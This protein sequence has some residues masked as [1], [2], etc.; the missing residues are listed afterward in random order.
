MQLVGMIFKQ[1]ELVWRTLHD[2]E[3]EGL[4][5]GGTG[6][7]PSSST[8]SSA[9]AAQA[10][11]VPVCTGPVLQACSWQGGLAAWDHPQWIVEVK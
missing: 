10:S 6:G 4:L 1:G 8:C 9:L 3:G 2:Q 7:S 11:L 5:E